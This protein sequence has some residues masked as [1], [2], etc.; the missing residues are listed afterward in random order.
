MPSFKKPI[1]NISSQEELLSVLTKA[2]KLGVKVRFEIPFATK[3]EAEELSKNPSLRYSPGFKYSDL[4][5]NVG[6]G[7]LSR[8]DS[9][10]YVII[11]PENNDYA[12]DQRLTISEL[13]NDL[14]H[15]DEFSMFIDGR[16]IEFRN[17]E[18]GT[19]SLKKDITNISSLEDFTNIIKKLVRVR[20]NDV[21]FEMPFLISKYRND[22][23]NMDSYTRIRNQMDNEFR[24]KYEII[25]TGKLENVILNKYVLIAPFDIN[26]L[27]DQRLTFS[28]LY[29]SLRND[30]E[31]Y[32]MYIDGKQITFR[33]S[34]NSEVIEGTKMVR[35]L[36][37]KED[38]NQSPIDVARRMGYD[39]ART[40]DRDRYDSSL[41]S[42]MNNH[43]GDQQREDIHKAYIAG[44]DDFK[45]GKKLDEKD[46]GKPGKNFD[47]IAKKAAKEYG[48]K[49]AGEKVAGA[50]LAKLRK[51]H[52]RKYAESVKEDMGDN[53]SPIDIARRMGYR[54]AK[55]GDRNRFDSSLRA[56]MNDHPGDKQRED[57]HKAFIAGMD[58]FKKDP[59]KEIK[60]EDEKLPVKDKKETKK[61]YVIE[62]SFP[63]DGDSTLADLIQDEIGKQAEVNEVLRTRRIMEFDYKNESMYNAALEAIRNTMKLKNK[64]DYKLDSRIDDDV[65]EVPDKEVEDLKEE[66]KQVIQANR[67]PVT[68][69]L[70]LIIE[71]LKWASKIRAN[72][73][74][75]LKFAAN[76]IENNNGS[77]LDV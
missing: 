2:L 31:D 19:Q 14:V 8:I 63:Y 20:S 72:E 28:N 74:E 25:S 52:P 77:I 38:D 50:V 42:L 10:K 41:R 64:T 29:N 58:D 59:N 35:R 73:G 57:I 48:S 40:G 16:Q 56:L 22:L 68:V 7:D 39:A 1:T 21:L 67:Y 49:E 54:A 5:K 69:T 47:K 6:Y 23:K 43:P 70:P 62:L 15:S 75:I 24:E 61:K 55:A 46:L 51:A 9:K 34:Q 60:E 4:Y 30:S 27:A 37:I 44:M 36:R 12:T 33:D 53:Q 66:I 18:M 76:L 3:K 45:S 13:Y 17:K 32:Q 71:G 11:T 26:L 65:V